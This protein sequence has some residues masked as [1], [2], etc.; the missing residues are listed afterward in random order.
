MLTNI[1][2]YWATGAFGSS[3]W[4]Y[5]SRMHRD[6]RTP[7][8]GTINVPIGYVEFPREI[9]RPPRSNSRICSRPCT[10]SLLIRLNASFLNDLRP[11]GVFSMDEA[12]ELRERVTRWRLEAK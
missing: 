1:T 9:L 12:S 3:S 11:L 6:W 5:Y 2:L 4:P 7:A 8:G 10:A